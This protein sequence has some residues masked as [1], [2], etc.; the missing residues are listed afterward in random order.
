MH[1]RRGPYPVEDAVHPFQCPLPLLGMAGKIGLVHLYHIGLDVGDLLG[2]HVGHGQA[3]LLPAPVVAVEQRLAQ[4]V[5]SREGELELV[6]R[7]ASGEGEVA[8]QI[9]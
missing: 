9:E 2:E 6:R 1:R 5:R 8:R 7:Q 3:Q 4:H